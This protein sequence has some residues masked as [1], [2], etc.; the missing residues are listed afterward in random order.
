[1]SG[2]PRITVSSTDALAQLTV[3][4]VSQSGFKVTIYN[5][6]S[7]GSITPTIEWIAEVTVSNSDTSDSIPQAIVLDDSSWLVGHAV[8]GSGCI[9]PLNL[10]CAEYSANITKIEYFNNTWITINGGVFHQK[11][12]AYSYINAPFDTTQFGNAQPLLVR[13]NAIFT[14]I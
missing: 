2:I 7:G 3:S 14:K 6:W 9:I 11:I 12:G 1:M 10:P 4:E 5:S 8:F 13:I